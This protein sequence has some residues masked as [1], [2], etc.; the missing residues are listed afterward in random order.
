MGWPGLL[1]PSGGEGDSGGVE[2]LERQRS[3]RG[4]EGRLGSARPFR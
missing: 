2:K 1:W 4:A 3:W